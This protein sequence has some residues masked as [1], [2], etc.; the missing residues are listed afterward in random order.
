MGKITIE[1]SDK[2]LEVDIK[3]MDI[4]QIISVLEFVKLQ[5]LNSM[6]GEG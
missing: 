6:M 1:V 3:E 4:H 5:Q 2:G